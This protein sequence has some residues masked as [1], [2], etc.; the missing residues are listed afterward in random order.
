MGS[1][2][3]Y[4]LGPYVWG[5][6]SKKVTNLGAWAGFLSGAIVIGGYIILQTLGILT[7]DMPIVSTVAMLVSFTTVPLVSILGKQ[8]NSEYIK[9]AFGEA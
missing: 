2:F 9:K 3:R 5:I 8:M 7:I 1:S 4:V 6:W